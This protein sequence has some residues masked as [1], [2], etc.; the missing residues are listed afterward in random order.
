VSL[1]H[2]RAPK[3]EP[4]PQTVRTR[5][6]R[7]LARRL[8]RSRPCSRCH[9]DTSIKEKPVRP[10]SRMPYLFLCIIISF[11]SSDTRVQARRE[12][13]GRLNHGNDEGM[14]QTMRAFLLGAVA[15][16]YPL[17]SE[18]APAPLKP[19]V[20]ESLSLRPHFSNTE[21]WMETCTG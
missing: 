12:I 5:F 15:L 9:R 21:A 4:L 14:D 16:L 8:S 20:I 6:A 3:Q 1:E 7:C 2:L 10:V 13:A 19:P 11:R 17:T 18:H